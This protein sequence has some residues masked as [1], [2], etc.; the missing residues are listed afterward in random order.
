MT[1]FSS[2]CVVHASVCE[3]RHG[4]GANAS[5]WISIAL[6]L[7][8]EIGCASKVLNPIGEQINS[9]VCIELTTNQGKDRYVVT[10]D[11]LVLMVKE[12]LKELH[13]AEPP[14]NSMA[15]PYLMTLV[16]HDGSRQDLPISEI[17]PFN[18][19]SVQGL[20][21]ERYYLR[22]FLIKINGAVYMGATQRLIQVIQSNQRVETI[23]W[24]KPL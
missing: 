23:K 11:D 24:V 4:F 12:T 9:V 20:A 8:F 16:F 7:A 15:M 17:Q 1:H 19:D 21:P 22:N 2:W 10:D 18:A 5:F 6:I 3:V 13:L 14:A